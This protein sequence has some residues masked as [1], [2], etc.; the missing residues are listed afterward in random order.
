ML[1]YYYRKVPVQST[2]TSYNQGNMYCCQLSFYVKY[3][4]KHSKGQL[5]KLQKCTIFFKKAI[6]L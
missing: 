6:G 3:A 5:S 4:Y 1:H 2:G